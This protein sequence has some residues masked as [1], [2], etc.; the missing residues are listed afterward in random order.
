MAALI[1]HNNG[2]LALTEF[3]QRI[4]IFTVLTFL[5]MC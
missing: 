4:L 5:A 1:V 2:V 3:R